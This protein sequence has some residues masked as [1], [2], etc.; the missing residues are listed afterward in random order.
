MGDACRGARV[1]DIHRV[2]VDPEVRHAGAQHQH[3][4][5]D[6]A[7]A[8]L[9]GD[10]TTIHH[11]LYTESSPLVYPTP[12][13]T[14]GGRPRPGGHHD[15]WSGASARAVSPRRTFFQLP[16]EHDDRSLALS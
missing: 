13:A 5:D 6:L 4:G 11:Q 16:S 1:T 10:A 14:G 8:R 7:I 3:I 2:Q 9:A 12:H 15:A